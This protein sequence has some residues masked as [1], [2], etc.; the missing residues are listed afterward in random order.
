MVPLDAP[1]RDVPGHSFVIRDDRVVTV[2]T[3]HAEMMVTDPRDVSLYVEKFDRF[4]SVSRAADAMREQVEGIR[5][6]FSRER[7][8]H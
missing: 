5:D 1:Q 3:T 2:E 6:G 7:E 4:A 8:T